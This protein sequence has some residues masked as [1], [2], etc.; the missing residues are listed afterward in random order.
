MMTE[1]Q[2]HALVVEMAGVCG[3][4]HYHTYRSTKS[5][6]GFPDLVLV[7]DRTIFVELKTNEGKLT[8]DQC[9]WRDA[10]RAAGSEWHLWRPRDEEKI[11][12]LLGCG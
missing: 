6:P 12:D 5:P 2:W 8:V 1:K 3:W 11:R 10:L 9:L 7:K 4:M